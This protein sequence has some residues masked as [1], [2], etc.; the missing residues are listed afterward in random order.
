MVKFIEKSKTE[1]N[2]HIMFKVFGKANGI[3]KELPC[4]LQPQ[5][6]NFELPSKEVL[7]EVV[8]LILKRGYTKADIGA[9]LGMSSERNRTLNYWLKE[10]S[11][12]QISKSHWLCLSQLAGLT[13]I[14][15]LHAENRNETLHL[16]HSNQIRSRQR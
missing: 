8:N 1:A 15:M 14:T 16:P 9:F 10:T 11:E 13:F 5:D 2:S 7:N 12:K 3:D 4:F 6:P